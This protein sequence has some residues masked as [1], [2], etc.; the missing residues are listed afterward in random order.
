MKVWKKFKKIIAITTFCGCLFVSNSAHAY[1]WPSTDFTKIAKAI[2]K[3]TATVNKVNVQ[4]S[5][6][7]S[8]TQKI[9]IVS[10]KLAKVKEY[11]N[12]L[13]QSIDSIRANIE[14]ISDSVKGAI[15]SVEETIE[16][17]NSAINDAKK[18]A[19]EIV[20][21]TVDTV[22][23]QVNDGATEEEVNKTISDAKEEAEKNRQTVNQKLDVASQQITTVLDETSSKLSEMIENLPADVFDDKQLQAYKEEAE[24]I[25]KKIEDLKSNAQNIIEKAKSNYNEQY[26]VFVSN[27]FEEYSQAVSDYYSGKISKDELAQAGEKLKNS[28]SAFDG[29]IDT[30][31]I[32]SLIEDAK[33]IASEVDALGE[34]IINDA[35]N[36]K[37]YD[38]SHILLKEEMVFAFNYKDTKQNAHLSIISSDEAKGADSRML[39]P[40]ELDCLQA[41]GGGSKLKLENLEKDVNEQN[42]FKTCVTMAKTE[43]DYWKEFGLGDDPYKLPLYRPYKKNGVYMHIEEDYSAANLANVT[44]IKQH[45]NSWKGIKEGEDKATDNS[46]I[47][48]LTG[49]VDKVNDQN[50][51]YIAWGKI[52][53][54]G[55]RQ[56][57]KLR[58]IDALDRAKWIVQQFGQFNNLYLD[59]RDDDFVNSTKSGLGK[60]KVAQDG[61]SNVVVQVFPN[62]MLYLCDKEKVEGMSGAE[63]S[64]VEKE[65]YNPE[66]TKKVEDKITNCMFV[67]AESS[68]RGTINNEEIYPGNTEQ[69]IL[70]WREKQVKAITDAGFETL[71]ISVINNYNSFKD[72]INSKKPQTP[73]DMT[74]KD[75]DNGVKNG[76]TFADS[77]V[78]NAKVNMYTTLQLLSIVEA[79]AQALQTEIL[80]DL[81]NFGYNHFDR[82]V[83][84]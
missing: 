35:S 34:K 30:K 37:E 12:M 2:E 77:M 1:I 20:N 60:V 56:L 49:L 33:N 11:A 63:V 51:T 64:L 10:D 59:K 70:E 69:G 54:E 3:V 5:Q 23:N 39:L 21:D 45:I 50:N 38:D 25:S 44:Q 6:G 46:I 57:S 40:L 28:V 81:Q 7:R 24:E 58:S 66:A 32:D 48:E 31:E 67:F 65:K 80:K 71:L 13:Q 43:I 42:K 27:A 9:K 53:V 16:K 14:S 36:H 73:A 47:A 61:G 74:I 79:D 8:T 22:N 62:M 84:K 72:N 55:A 4:I 29:G 83:H 18:T 15:A 82:Q 52:G 68:S 41:D 76:K 19:E 26:S 78:E 75:L 17:A